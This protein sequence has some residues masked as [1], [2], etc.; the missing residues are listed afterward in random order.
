MGN[1]AASGGYYVSAAANLIVARNNTIT[2]SIGVILARPVAAG[3]FGKL[4]INPIAIERGAR[5]N[6]LDLRRPPTTDEITVLNEQLQN[7]YGGFKARVEQGRKLQPDAL[8]EMAGGRVWTGVEALERNLVDEVGG[9]RAAV[10][11][12]RQLG[13]IPGELPDVLIKLSPPRNAR[14]TPGEP[15]REAVDAMYAAFSELATTR[16]WA[17]APYEIFEDW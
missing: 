1:A 9:L 16:V 12:A 15:V 10:E 2:G 5:S 13:G 3:L 6:L 8:E 7:F 4:K 17:L 14:P 11:K